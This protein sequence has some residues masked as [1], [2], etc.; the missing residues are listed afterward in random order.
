M[1][2]DRAHDL[3]TN[4]AKA[5][6]AYRP[7]YPS[8]LYSLIFDFAGLTSHTTRT[9]AVDVATGQGQAALQLCSHFQKVLALDAN[10]QQ[11]AHARQAPNI[12]YIEADAHHTGLP[13]NCA[14][15]VTAASALHWFDQKL[16]YKEARRILKPGGALAA[17]AIPLGLATITVPQVSQAGLTQVGLTTCY[18]KRSP[19]A[20]SAPCSFVATSGEQI[21]M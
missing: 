14:E 2:N 5:Y 16:F 12:E 11:L 19:S 7:D 18:L 6:S 10:T 9:L 8:E 4:G 17:W 20:C 1:C 13:S 21:H 3:F 15:L